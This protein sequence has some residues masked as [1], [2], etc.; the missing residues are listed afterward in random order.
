M[1]GEVEGLVAL[2]EIRP[3]RATLITAERAGQVP[4]L[5][6]T[7]PRSGEERR[8]PGQLEINACLESS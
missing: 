4:E 5:V 2:R 1:E 6:Y 7:C 3:R 8:N